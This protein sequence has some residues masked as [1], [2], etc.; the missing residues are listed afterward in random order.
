[1]EGKYS[2]RVISILNAFNQ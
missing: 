2:S 1:M